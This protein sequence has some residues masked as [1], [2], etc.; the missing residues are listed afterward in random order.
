MCRGIFPNGTD[1]DVRRSARLSGI[2]R[3]AFTRTMRCKR[4]K[5]S[6]STER[7]DSEADFR[8]LAG[9]TTWARRRRGSVATGKSPDGL[10]GGWR[11][12]L[13]AGAFPRQVAHR[14]MRP[15]RGISGNRRRW[16]VPEV[17]GG[18]APSLRSESSTKIRRGREVDDRRPGT[19]SDSQPVPCAA[20]R[21][22]E[23]APAKHAN[24]PRRSAAKISFFVLLLHLRS[25]P[26]GS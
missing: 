10:A 25:T 22:T 5:C 20:A 15:P 11:G 26:I 17:D 8:T 18:G 19:D 14:E 4:S 21:P 3:L 6:R 1:P 16:V 13:R 24:P 23:T 12:W 7:T 2:T 9:S